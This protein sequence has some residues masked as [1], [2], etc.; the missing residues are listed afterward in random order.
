MGVVTIYR[1]Q[2]QIFGLIEGGNPGLASSITE[3]ELKISIG[4]VINQL[5]KVEH[6][7][8]N[9]KLGEKIPN[10]SVLALY[11]NIAVTESNGKSKASLPI[12]PIKLPRNMGCWAIYPKYTLGGDYEYDKEWI[13]VQMGQLGLL[14]SQPLIN[15][16]LGQVAY[17]NY[18][19]EVIANKNVKSLYP[20]IVLAMRLVV[21]DVSQYSDFDPLPVLPEQEWQIIQEV[22]KLYSNQRIPDKII[23]STAKENQGVPLKQQ[24]QT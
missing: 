6:F 8:I 18:G 5:L 1:L 17:E 20:D 4:N 11:E 15:D 10:G 24:Q 21:M 23:D 2:E 14:N 13:P 16:L 12:K 19:M 22:Y 7:S 3:N 9:E